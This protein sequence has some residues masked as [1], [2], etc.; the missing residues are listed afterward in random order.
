[1]LR[2]TI[3]HNIHLTREQRYAL[4][5]GEDVSVVGVSIPIWFIK[6]GTSEPAN[7]IFCRYYLKNPKKE[8]PI[9]IL[10]DGY[11][12]SLPYREGKTISINED[13]WRDLNMKNPS[14]LEDMYVKTVKEVSSKNILDIEDGGSAFLNYRELNK[15]MI[16][17]KELNI[18]HHITINKIENLIDS[19]G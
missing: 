11:E 2:L 7:E 14:K 9:K 15:V 17:N 18:M 12:I 16:K 3:H 19:L 1:M 6:K 13:E 8:T 5:N 4:H 10:D